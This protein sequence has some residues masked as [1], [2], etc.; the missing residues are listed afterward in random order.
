MT[1]GRCSFCC[2]AGAKHRARIF[3]PRGVAICA[4]C[5]AELLPSA[6]AREMSLPIERVHVKAEW[7]VAGESRAHGDS[8]S[9]SDD[10]PL[11][12]P[13]G[14]GFCGTGLDELEQ[15]FSNTS[16]TARICDRCVF[17]AAEAMAEEESD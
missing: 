11:A 17:M 12:V 5:V 16:G 2:L 8:A 1:E 4:A 7:L 9:E 15:L 13:D 3:G 6:S 10:A 14:C